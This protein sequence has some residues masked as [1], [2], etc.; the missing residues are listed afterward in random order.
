MSSGKVVTFAGLEVRSCRLA[1]ALYAYGPCLGDYVAVASPNDHRTHEVVFGLQRSGLYYMMVNSACS[2]K[3]PRASSGTAGRAADHLGR[4]RR[5]GERPR[6]ADSRRRPSP[7]DRG[8]AAEGYLGFDDFVA[9]HPREPLSEKLCTH[10]VD[11]SMPSNVLMQASPS[12]P[13]A[14]LLGFP[15]GIANFL[16]QVCFEGRGSNAS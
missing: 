5:R 11:S 2:A 14:A 8:E 12:T 16:I 6:F 7:H 10:H 4:V 9:A 15:P 13:G 3:E 1:Q